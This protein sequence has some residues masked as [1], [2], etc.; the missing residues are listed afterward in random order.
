M[1]DASADGQLAPSDRVSPDGTAVS[2]D[3]S[4]AGRSDTG[5]AADAT[6]RDLQVDASVPA[7]HDAALAQDCESGICTLPRAMALAAGSFHTCALL[8][9]GRVACWGQNAEGQLGTGD[10]RDL[11]RPTLVPGVSGATAIAAGGDHSCALISDGTV[12]C[13]GSSVVS[14][15]ISGITSPQPIAGLTKVLAIGSGEQHSCVVIEGG[16]LRCWGDN[17]SGQLGD[18]T[19][20]ESLVP[21]SVPLM[22]V[23]G[24]AAG[25]LDT[26][27]TCAPAGD[28]VFCW[29]DGKLGQLG[30]GATASS[31]SPVR[32]QG[33]SGRA[34]DV[35]VGE[36]HACARQVDNQV[37]CWGFNANGQLGIGTTSNSSRAVLV[38]GLGDA[39]SVS[40]AGGFGH[41]FTCALRTGGGVQCW[42]ANDVGQLGNGLG[43]D[44][45]QPTDVAG[46]DQAVAI[47]AGGGHACA[48]LATGGIRCWGYGGWGELGNGQTKEVNPLPMA[49]LGW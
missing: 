37:A 2:L 47:T 25:G 19:T 16:V 28:G 29:G 21:V 15:S 26:P 1:S 9:D 14:L 35:S 5:S 39:L 31:P 20:Q 27:F 17:G 3:G 4:A 10:T 33:L 22:S 38:P 6:T 13:W 45:P 32:V 44:S 41:G 12:R 8:V 36:G 34:L 30:N 49:V 46:I 40:A 24:V 43:V 42:G 7:I 11:S 48:I 18:G 23:E